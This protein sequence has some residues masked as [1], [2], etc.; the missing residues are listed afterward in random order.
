M[1]IRWKRKRFFSMREICLFATYSVQVRLRRQLLRTLY[2]IFLQVNT[3]CIGKLDLYNK[4]YQRS[5][6]CLNFFLYF[7]FLVSA[8][9][10]LAK[11]PSCPAISCS[12]A[13]TGLASM[14]AFLISL[15]FCINFSSFSF[16]SF[17]FF[18]NS[19]FLSSISIAARQLQTS[20]SSSGD[21]CK[22]D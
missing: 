2:T 15:A 6:C 20:N 17:S 12:W 4:F 13:V 1:W 18:S 9:M 10:W 19:F 22:S 8:K 7:C 3:I 11:Q 5:C 14:V 21:S 16:R